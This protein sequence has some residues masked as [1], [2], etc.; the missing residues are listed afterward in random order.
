MEGGW[1]RMSVRREKGKVYV[2]AEGGRSQLLVPGEMAPTRLEFDSDIYTCASWFDIYT[3]LYESSIVHLH[4]NVLYADL[5]T[6]ELRAGYR[7]CMAFKSKSRRVISS[8]ELLDLAGELTNKPEEWLPVE[9]YDE[10]FTPIEA[11]P[12]RETINY[13]ANGDSWGP[14]SGCNFRIIL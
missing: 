8:G 11:P 13:N 10:V 14:L 12:A 1:Y 4:G 9:E 3:D 7:V 2:E 5:E 6:E